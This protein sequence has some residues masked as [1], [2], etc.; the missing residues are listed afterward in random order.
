MTTERRADAPTENS[1]SRLRGHKLAAPLATRYASATSAVAVL[2]IAG[3]IGC[4][5]GAAFPMSAQAPI[6]LGQILGVIGLTLGPALIVV[7]GR[8]KSVALHGFLALA[9]A[10]V[11]VL[12]A[13]STTS[14][15]VVLTGVDYMCIGWIAA[16][17]LPRRAAR[18]HYGLAVAGFSSGVLVGGVPG[19]VVPAFVIAATVVASAEMLAHFVNQLRRLA[20]LDPLTGLANRACFTAAAENE[21]V[22]AARRARGFTVAMIDM[23]NF[24]IVNDTHGHLAGDALLIELASTWQTQLRG[25]DLLARFG[26]DEFALLMPNTT[27]L[28]GKRVLRRL[29]DAHPA[30]WSAG[31]VEWDGDGGLDAILRRADRNLYEAKEAREQ[32]SRSCP[33]EAQDLATS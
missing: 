13:C 9:T 32:G 2:Y 11:S 33:A 29:R 7:R 14:A 10:L 5:L 25:T 23:D 21:M 28:E 30:K 12:V 1:R 31:I 3:G 26:G 20:A 8:M 16:Y 15:G 18:I 4:L 17:F 24:K 22:L 19:L 6:G 27:V